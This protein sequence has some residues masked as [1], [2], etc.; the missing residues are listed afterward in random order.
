MKLNADCSNCSACSV[1]IPFPAEN[2]FF[3]VQV[4]KE[5]KIFHFILKVIEEEGR[6]WRSS[7]YGN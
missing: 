6:M 5:V 7:Y 2:D 1:C 3:L 4:F